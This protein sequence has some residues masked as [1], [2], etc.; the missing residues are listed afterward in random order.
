[1]KTIYIIIIIIIFI[2]VVLNL[3]YTS[4][5][6]QKFDQPA[7]QLT[8]IGIPDRN[9]DTIINLDTRRYNGDDKAIDESNE[10]MKQSEFSTQQL[11]S[12]VIFYEGDHTLIGELGLEKCIQKCKG[13]CVEYGNTGDGHCFPTEYADITKYPIK[14]S[15]QSDVISPSK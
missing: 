9:N 15:L 13:M 11:F 3:E 6:L 7:I 2:G 4:E 12:D 1:M 14:S 10:K 8:K 5:H